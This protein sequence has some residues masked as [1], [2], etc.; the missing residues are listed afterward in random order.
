MENKINI[1]VT[2]DD[3]IDQDY[4]DALYAAHRREV[5]HQAGKQV[6]QG[7]GNAARNIGK[8]AVYVMTPEPLRHN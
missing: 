5:I 4:Y 2:R 7:L 3:H 1:I 8:A 6:L